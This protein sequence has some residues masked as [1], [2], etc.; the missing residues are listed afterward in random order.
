MVFAEWWRK[1]GGGGQ[2]LA[3][4][5]G[6]WVR[7]WGQGRH[8]S[9]GGTEAG[10]H[11]GLWSCVCGEG[12]QVELES[13]LMLFLLCCPPPPHPKEFSQLKQVGQPPPRLL[14]CCSGASLHCVK[15]R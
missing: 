12:D 11:T 1:K 15:M 2:R 14:S 3:W 4:D 9:G 6:D 5:A 7:R 13:Y 10:P 8:G